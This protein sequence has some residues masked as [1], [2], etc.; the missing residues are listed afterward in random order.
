MRRTA[1]LEARA[2]AL[3]GDEEAVRSADQR[4]ESL[5]D[6]VVPDELDGLGGLLTYPEIEQLYYTVES[7]VLLGHGDAQIAV[8]AEQAVRG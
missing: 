7:E 2:A 8:Q 3:L 4:A 6:Q 5:R 1:A